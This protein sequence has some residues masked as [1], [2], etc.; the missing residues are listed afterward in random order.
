ME[1]ALNSA[2]Y[3][4]WSFVL[5]NR[6]RPVTVP[7][8]FLIIVS[9]RFSPFTVHMRNGQ[10]RSVMVKNGERWKTT[11]NDRSRD[12]H[13]I[14]MG[15]SRSRKIIKRSTVYTSIIMAL[16]LIQGAK[17]PFKDRQF[18]EDLGEFLDFN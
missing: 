15:R 5:R 9:G 18:L 1:S 12:G 7:W 6:D 2:N 11:R 4:S 3:Y 16:T 8:P 10:E 14:V 17:H 13:G